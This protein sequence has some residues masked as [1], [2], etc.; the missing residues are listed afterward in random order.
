[1]V[2]NDVKMKHATRAQPEANVNGICV[3]QL[4]SGEKD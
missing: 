3:L 1:M 2:G 4:E